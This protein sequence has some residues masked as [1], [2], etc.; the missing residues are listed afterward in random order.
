LKE[1]GKKPRRRWG[2]AILWWIVLLFATSFIAGAYTKA[3]YEFLNSQLGTNMVPRTTITPW[4]LTLLFLIGCFVVGKI[5]LS[6]SDYE[7]KNEKDSDKP[8]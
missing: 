2:M 8:E 7:K 6:P 1:S 5:F 4:W 3:R